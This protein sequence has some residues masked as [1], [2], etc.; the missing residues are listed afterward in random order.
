MNKSQIKK[1]LHADTKANRCQS[2]IALIKLQIIKGGTNESS[3]VRGE[4]NI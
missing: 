4:E 3:P 2:A 1:V